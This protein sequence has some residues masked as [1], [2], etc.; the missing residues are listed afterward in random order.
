ML[1][2]IE[3]IK[4]EMLNFEKEKSEQNLLLLVC[5]FA[6]IILLAPQFL[7]ILEQLLKQKPAESNNEQPKNTGSNYSKKPAEK[8]RSSKMYNFSLIPID[9]DFDDGVKCI[10]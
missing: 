8:Q 6:L 10:L 2:D 1:E 5:F 7:Q 3:D 9:L 4:E